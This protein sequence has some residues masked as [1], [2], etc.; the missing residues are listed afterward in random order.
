[1]TN[2]KKM[3]LLMA[4]LEELLEL[5]RPE[6]PLRS[7]SER[8]DLI[9]A[10]VMLGI[11]PKEFFAKE[12]LWSIQEIACMLGTLHVTNEE[13]EEVWREEDEQNNTITSQNI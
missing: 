12:L 5:S 9:S 4:V 1:M 3:L 10:L 2:A 13:V 8:D 6:T 7:R 11:E